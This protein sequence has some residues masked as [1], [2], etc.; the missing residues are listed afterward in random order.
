MT[1]N[2]PTVSFTDAG[3]VSPS[4]ASV[5][6]GVQ[7]DMN[8]A[9]GGNLNPSLSTPQGQLATSWSAI[10]GY[11]NDLF[12][13]LTQQVDPA[14]SSG[15]MQDAI[16]RIY[17]LERDPGASTVVS[18]TCTGVAGTE[19]PQS[20]LAV[21]TDGN[22]YYAVDGGTIGI[23]GTVVLSFACSVIGPIACPTGT[24]T[25]I[26]Q[27]IP[28]WDAVTN[29]SDG[30]VGHDVESRQDFEARRAASVAINSIGSL[31]TILGAVLD[32]DGVLDAYVT[33]NSTGSPLTIGGYELDPYS[34]YVAA[35]GGT[36][37]DVAQAIWRKK[38]PGCAYNGNTTVIVEDT[39]SGYVTPYPSYDV[40]FE[41]PD[42]LPI[43]FSVELATNAQ[44][45]SNAI[46]LIKEA[47][48]AAFNGQDGGQRARIGSTIYATRFIAP[49]AALGT[50]MQI[51]SL[52]IGSDNTLGAEFT[53]DISGTT[54]DVSA[55]A[56]GTLEV[57]Q[58]I[59]GPNIEEGT[60]IIALGTGSGGT[61]TYELSLS[62][63]VASEDMTG[64]A[65][66]QTSVS[67]NI[68]QV[69]TVSSV[70][71]VVVIS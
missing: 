45:P 25:M 71:I 41:R 32:V 61:G 37:D 35:V 28:G 56:S 33:E 24:L 54:M 13:N 49:V 23:S 3:F 51:V 17:F 60:Y 70:N 19:I 50:W 15:R 20:A 11:A 38:A 1:T 66:N 62:Q 53:A 14:Y 46:S 9:F 67:V 63:T 4:E 57:G 48:I 10:I 26:Y 31:P 29:L 34:V 47:I 22:F 2:V 40:T 44:V 8:A 69:P 7:A 6:A 5:L 58:F 18:A 30:V 68:D 16:A 64:A 65:A 12:C 42:A 43:Y 55:V 59:S 52:L 39:R 27:A 21:A 36:N